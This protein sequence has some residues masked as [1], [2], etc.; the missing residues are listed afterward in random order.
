MVG[1]QGLT[2]PNEQTLNELGLDLGKAQGGDFSASLKAK[3]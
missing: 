1:Q 2:L 3:A